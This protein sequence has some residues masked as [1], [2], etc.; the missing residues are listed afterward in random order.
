MTS[1]KKR[2]R[3]RPSDFGSTVTVRHVSDYT[4]FFNRSVF[5]T[6]GLPIG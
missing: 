5:S 6:L 4:L 2:T 3:R 1:D